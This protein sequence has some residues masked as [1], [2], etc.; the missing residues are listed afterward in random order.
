MEQPSPDITTGG[1]ESRD[2]VEIIATKATPDLVC[3]LLA[4]VPPSRTG[5]VNVARVAEVLDV[6]RST[7]Y[8]WL[9]T[10]DER[11]F[12][13]DARRILARYA[14]LRG[15]GGYLWPRIDSA[16]SIRH[17]AYLED[18]LAGIANITR[19]PG[20]YTTWRPATTAAEVFTYHH[21]LAKVYGVAYATTTTN[22]RRILRGGATII[23]SV[24]APSVLHAKAIKY[25][26]LA[27]AGDERCIAPRELIGEGRTEVWRQRAGQ[28]DLAHLA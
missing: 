27:L 7:V 17:Q 10:A 16:T 5:G 11:E 4:A 3:W 24:Q 14:V 2:V 18:A 1:L 19:N 23:Q 15:H 26:T 25:S 9:K 8:R 20:A 28:I 12:E 6:S 21:P 22:R 13:P